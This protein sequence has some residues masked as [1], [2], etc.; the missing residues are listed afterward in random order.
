MIY[1]NHKTYLRDRLSLPANSSS[2]RKAS[3]KYFAEARV[4][5]KRVNAH[6]SNMH[7][8][9]IKTNPLAKTRR[10]DSENDRDCAGKLQV[11]NTTITPDNY[12]YNF[13]YAH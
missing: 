9:W 3:D 1:Q 7:V 12:Y 4:Y 6:I 11:L 13:M 2:S 10:N 8:S 5:R